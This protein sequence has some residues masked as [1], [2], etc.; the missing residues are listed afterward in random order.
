MSASAD[1][2]EVIADRV[3]DV[4]IL[5][6]SPIGNGFLPYERFEI[7]LRRSDPP[8]VAQQRDVLRG[9]GV[10]AVL[11]IDLARDKIV[12]IRQFR[13]AAHLAT[14]LGEMVEIVAGRV[15][16]G[17]TASDA[18]ARECFEEIGLRPAPLVELYTVV[19]SPG[20]SDEHVTFFVGSV[21]FGEIA[22]ARRHRSRRGNL[23]VC[24][25]D[26][27]RAGGARRQYD[28]QRAGCERAAMAGAAS[29]RVGAIA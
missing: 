17:E 26:R 20:I 19:P 4:E 21:D 9:G 2:P 25:A 13:L 6:R 28:P 22:V 14:G 12:L 24:G 18:A 15:D 11:P 23:S 7:V 8:R 29:P 10:A 27:R 1:K 5:E 16:R 3:A